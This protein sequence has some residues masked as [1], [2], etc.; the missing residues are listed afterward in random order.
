MATDDVRFEGMLADPHEQFGSDLTASI[1]AYTTAPSATLSA[2]PSRPAA[3]VMRACEPRWG[4]SQIAHQLLGICAG[5][6]VEDAVGI[7]LV[8]WRERAIA[9]GER[10][11]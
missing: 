9:E 5:C 8:R 6:P 1:L 4:C 2:Q 7:E 11:G 10:R 3:V